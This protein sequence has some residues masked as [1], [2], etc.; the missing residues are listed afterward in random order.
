M[1]LLHWFQ[2]LNMD[3]IASTGILGIMLMIAL[4]WRI[5]RRHQISDRSLQ[6]SLITSLILLA[7]FIFH[8]TWVCS[9][10]A[11]ICP[12]C[13]PVL[14]CPALRT[15]YYIHVTSSGGSIKFSQNNAQ[16]ACKS[17][18]TGWDLANYEDI[19]QAQQQGIQNCNFGFIWHQATASMKYCVVMPQP[20]NP[21]CPQGVRTPDGESLGVYC[22]GSRQDLTNPRGYPLLLGVDLPA[23]KCPPCP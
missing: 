2:Y 21:S 6:L 22:T 9:P 7:P 1:E 8:Y 17:L 23:G 18:G 3:A 12:V 11:Y 10:T 15:L 16:E 20:G 5:M 19:S 13:P 4:I 14:E